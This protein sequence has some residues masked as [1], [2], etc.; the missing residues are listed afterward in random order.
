MI[1]SLLSGMPN[2][3]DGE[4]DLVLKVEAL[5]DEGPMDEVPHDVKTE[6]VPVNPN[7]FSLATT[8]SSAELTALEA[9]VKLEQE[10]ATSSSPLVKSEDSPADFVTSSPSSS[11][12]STTVA[13]PATLGPHGHAQSQSE[14]GISSEVDSDPSSSSKPIEDG[15]ESSTSQSR[16]ASPSLSFEKPHSTSMAVPPP[17]PPPQLHPLVSLS[18][19]LERSDSLFEEYPPS[20]PSLALSSVMGPQSVIFTWSTL[21]SDMPSNDAAERMVAH[22]ELVVY[23]YVEETRETK[24]SDA[25]KND[26]SSQRRKPKKSKARRKLARA[27]EMRDKKTMVVGAVLVLG[28]AMAVYGIKSGMAGEGRHGH[29]IPREWKKLGGWVGGAL[30]GV[31]ERVWNL[32]GEKG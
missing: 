16:P 30:V 2:L 26:S 17:S 23:P 27:L 5:D 10:V 13:T 31:G 15:P 1:H 24:E 29:T 20:H 9:E 7:V 4:D 8:S 32:G 14:S 28:V 25:N 11:T 18:S 6:I 12:S 19:L 3:T 21:P 22:P